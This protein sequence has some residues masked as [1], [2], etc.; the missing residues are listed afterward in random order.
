MRKG[1]HLVELRDWTQIEMTGNDR[2]SFLHNMCTNEINGLKPGKGCEAFLTNVQGKILAYVDVSCLE[3]SLTLRCAPGQADAITAH[4][5]RYI[6]R[7]DVTLHDRTVEWG[8]WLAA[9]DAIEAMIAEQLG[10]Q[11]PTE[12][13]LRRTG[14][15]TT[16][17][18]LLSGPRD[19]LQ[20]LTKSLVEDGAVQCDDEIFEMARIE[21]GTPL[22]GRDV[23]E[24]NLPQEVALNDLAISFTKGCYL[25]QETVA[26]I[27]ALGH[28]NRTLVG[29]RLSGRTV[30]M[31]GEQLHVDGKPIGKIT[32]AVFSETLDSPLALAY[33]RRGHNQPGMTLDGPNGPVEV[34]EL[35]V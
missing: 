33:V 35:P 10:G 34:I 12:I 29:V 6:I 17:A 13:C 16:T 25:G 27:D 14:M 19:V 9:G 20:R 31:V 15:V 7:E 24:E 21:A 11:P 1:A 8:L 28:V 18:F 22:Y 30:P 23:T 26:R 4:L 2:A 3:D 32:S 5:D